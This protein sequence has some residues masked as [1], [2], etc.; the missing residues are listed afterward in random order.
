MSLFGNITFRRQRAKSDSETTDKDDKNISKND[1]L[2]GTINSMPAISDDEDDETKNYKLELQRLTQELQSAHKEI[3]DLN[4][5]NRQL[6]LNLEDI[7]KKY[8]M[9][10]K[11]T[12]DLKNDITTPKKNK[13]QN[14]AYL[15]R[16][17]NTPRTKTPQSKKIPAKTHL[18]TKK[19]I[20]LESQDTST[21]KTPISTRKHIKKYPNV[22]L[23]SSNSRNP[24]L[25]LAEKTVGVDSK[26]CHHKYVSGGIM[27]QLSHIEKQTKALT[28]HDFFVLIVGEK[29]FETSK[30]YYEL[31]IF[32][33]EELKKIQ[34]TNVIICL[35]TYR[36]N[37]YSNIYNRRVE[38]FNSLLYMDNL[39]HKYAYILDSNKNLEYDISMFLDTKGTINDKGMKIIFDDL[40]TLIKH[41]RKPQTFIPVNEERRGNET[42]KPTANHGHKSEIGSNLFRDQ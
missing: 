9:C 2:D 32:I 40:S 10:K 33:R 16:Q 19:D 36:C 1:T 7:K 37:E 3:S 8:E 23:S 6:K 29:E 31:I 39:S 27:E 28:K 24:I 15:Q 35:P 26:I 42:N 21:T 25:Q 34:H 14:S 11:L 12:N 5:E 4:L 41:I 30:K 22:I 38:T 13:K 18:E 17:T 20:Q